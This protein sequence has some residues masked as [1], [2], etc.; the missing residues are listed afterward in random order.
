MSDIQTDEGFFSARDGLRLFWHTARAPAPVAHVAVVHGYAEHLGR[1]SEVT[2]ALVD[3]GYTAHL[4]DCRGHGQSGGKRAHV[5]AFDDYLSDLELFLARIKEQAAGLPVFILGHSHGGLI[6]ARYLLDKPEAVRGVVLSS[7]YFRLKLQ[8]SPLKIMA[9]K[10]MSRILPSL[11]MKN[12]LKAEQLTRDVAIQNATKADPLYQ[13]IA[14]P[15]WFTASNGAQET[16]MRRATEFVT[17][18]L[19]LFGGADPI[20]DPAAGRE[21]YEAA[22]SKDKQHKQ[23]D[24]LLHELFHEPER[25]M[26][27]KDLVGWLDERAR[28]AARAAAGK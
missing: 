1:H 7:P 28:G 25:D 13:Q 23:Y 6:A 12:E 14:T 18:F 8:V 11:P 5:A 2:R 15:G 26:V 27:F 4:I 22:T 20:A 16:V 17:P 21:F 10:L 19:L 9:G 24:G 3:A